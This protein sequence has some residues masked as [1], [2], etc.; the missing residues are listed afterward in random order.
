MKI[1]I[2]DYTNIG[3]KTA[4]GLDKHKSSIE[5]SILVKEIT[6]KKCKYILKK[7]LSEGRVG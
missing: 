2:V 1:H 7:L 5:S 6:C 4:C 3:H